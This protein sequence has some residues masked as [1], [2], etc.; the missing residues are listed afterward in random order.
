MNNNKAKY[1]LLIA[2][3]LEPE[4]IEKIRQV[5]PERFNVIFEPDL[6]GAPR[7]PAD[8]YAILDRTP[9]QEARW[10]ELLGKAD[11]IFDFDYSHRSDLPDLAPNLR[12]IQSTSAGIGQFINRL[13]YDTRLP[14]TIFTTASGV[15]ARPLAEYVV[16]AM[17]SHYKGLIQILDQQ[18]SSL[19]Q[20]MAGTDLEGRTI[21][22]VGLGSI[23][24]EVARMA[25][26]LGM[27]A[28]GTDL[29]PNPESVDQFFELENIRE[30]LPLAD[31][32]V[33]SVPHT[34]DTEKMIGAKEFG[35]MQKGTYF[36]NIA[37]GAVVDEPA[38]IEA[39]QSGQLAGAALDVF[40]KEPLPAESPLWCMPNVIISPHSA[41]TSDRENLRLTELLCDNMQRFLN[42]EPLRNV[43]NTK[44]LF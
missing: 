4:Y 7:Y 18:K 30:M 37:R 41:C 13:G 42:D 35:A 2:S 27:K 25:R 22:V 17:L 34:P 5:A 21:A 33:L 1:N 6:I 26:A 16:M 44:L 9:E 8:H 10:C 23:G 31:V 15:H 43:L 28:V 3:Y 32:I 12:W 19:W 36:I 40:A 29:Y 20:R 38:L 24:S 14:D 39:L 11:I